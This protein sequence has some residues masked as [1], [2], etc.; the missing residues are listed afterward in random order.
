MQLVS[1]KNGVDIGLAARA[2]CRTPFDGRCR[3]VAKHR[4][5]LFW[6]TLQAATG[7]PGTA[8]IGDTLSSAFKRRT[9][10]SLLE[11]S[12]IFHVK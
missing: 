5:T 12:R 7:L 4:L 1:L 10:P 9:S 8:S 6:A 11:S 2:R 3:A